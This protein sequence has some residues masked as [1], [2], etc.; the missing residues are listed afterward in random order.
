MPTGGSGQVSGGIYM[1]SA[2]KII[3]IDDNPDFLFTMGTFLKRNGYE[4]LTAS[5]GQKG[6]ELI[7]KERPDLILLDVMME[8]LFSGFE[9][10]R[11]VRTDPE[12]QNTPIIA[13]SGMSDD[14]GVKFEQT[15]DEEYFKPN[16]FLEKPVDKERLLE[17]M[18][19]LL[20][21]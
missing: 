2:S 13:I 16:A 8:T 19:E 7:K 21:T 6:V 10:C 14:L 15:T 11:Q 12:T 4:V 18:R 5:D 17:T 3:L 9:V 1:G 20:Q